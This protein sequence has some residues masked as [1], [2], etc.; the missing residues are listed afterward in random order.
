LNQFQNS[1]GVKEIEQ[2]L[3]RNNFLNTTPQNTDFKVQLPTV[4]NLYADIKIIPKVNITLFTQQKIKSNSGNDQ[5]TSQNII[6]VTP[7]FAINIFEAYIPVAINEISG[8]TAGFGFRLG[9]FFLGSNS[10]L[11][12]LTSDGKQADFYTGFRFGFL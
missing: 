5:I 10:V 12:A 8:T 7:R 3:I 9:G 6:S 4:F 1:N 11:T 2:V